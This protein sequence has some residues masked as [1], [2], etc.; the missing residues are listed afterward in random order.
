MR[1][2]KVKKIFKGHVSIRDDIVFDCL[3]KK[4]DLLVKYGDAEMLIPHNELKMFQRITPKVFTKKHTK[5]GENP[6]YKLLDYKWKPSR[7][8]MK[9]IPEKEQNDL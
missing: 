9:L 6:F 4:E 3:E 1:T 5:P 7:S 2:Y 8:Q